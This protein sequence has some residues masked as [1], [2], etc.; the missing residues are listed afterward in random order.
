MATPDRVFA[1]LS[2]VAAVPEAEKPYH[3][4]YGDSGNLP[5]TNI[6]REWIQTEICNVRGREQTF[7]INECGFAVRSLSTSMTYDDF[8]N[9]SKVR[10]V[11]FDDLAQHLKD[12]LC[13]QEVRF[14]RY[15]LRKRHV[16]FPTSTGKEYEFAQPTSIAHVDA[17]LWSTEL[18]MAKQYG[19]QADALMKHRFQWINV[20]KP[21]RGPVNDW[22]LCFCDASTVAHA[23]AE[24]TDMVYPEYF[25]ENLS[26]RFNRQQKWFYLSD[27]KEDEIIVF[28]QSDSNTDNIPGV[29]HCSF[30]N[31]RT[32]SGELP[33]ESIEARALVIY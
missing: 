32:D 24:V 4:M 18:E 13:A 25:T 6:T 11:Y 15:G 31:P 9:D 28:K 22:P 7:H 17:T 5:R 30:D 10:S 23:D 19:D 1:K 29:P 27:H 14:F 12:F 33:R 20:W 3:M 2:Y 26:L 21:L 8:N 16:K